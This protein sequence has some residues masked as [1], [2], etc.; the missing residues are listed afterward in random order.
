MAE[1]AGEVDV[2]DSENSAG[3]EPALHPVD[4][5]GRIGQVRQQ[6]PGIDK[7]EF[8]L[9]LACVDVGL[10][11]GYVAEPESG[12]LLTRHVELDFIE[13]NPDD[14]TRGPYSPREFK[15]HIPAAT[16]GVE[17]CHS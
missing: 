4:R 10:M 2:F 8:R 14:A 11:K 17:T 6:K 15:R 3:P 13:V 5:G 9:E 7:V 16:S 12:R 1:M